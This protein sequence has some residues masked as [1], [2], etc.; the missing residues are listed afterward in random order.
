MRFKFLLAIIV[1]NC[2]AF[3][4]CATK[5][6][7]ALS[8]FTV[9][10]GQVTDQATFQAVKDALVFLIWNK[11]TNCTCGTTGRVCA[12]LDSSFFVQPTNAG[13]QY[14]FEVRWQDL[15]FLFDSTI[16]DTCQMRVKVIAQQYKTSPADTLADTV[17]FRLT[18]QGRSQTQTKNLVIQ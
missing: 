11:G 16:G 14:Y 15:G 6:P 3:L 1:L 17:S 8:E 7:T 9:F 5:K 2:V 13:G 10:T 12:A 18:L 4:S